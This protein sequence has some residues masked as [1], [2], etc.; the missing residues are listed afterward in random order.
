MVS[1]VKS[2]N[3]YGPETKT[4]QNPYK[5]DFEVRVQ[6][7]IMNVYDT[8]SLMVIHP[9]AKNGKLMSNQRK[10]MAQTLI[11]VKNPINLM[12]I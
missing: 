2:K 5:F 12:Y 8:H 11:H 7:R 1:N 10:V 4:C 3:S 6:G 9:S